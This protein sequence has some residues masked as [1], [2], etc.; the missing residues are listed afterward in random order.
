F[1]DDRYIQGDTIKAN[2]AVDYYFGSPVPKALVKWRL[3]KR[4]R[5]SNF[6]SVTPMWHRWYCDV[7]R[8][9]WSYQGKQVATGEGRTDVDGKFAVS[10]PIPREEHDVEY[11]LVADVTD[12]SRRQQTGSG[13]VPAHQAS[14][15]L[16]IAVERNVVEAGKPFD[17]TVHA[18]DHGSGRPAAD[19]PIEVVVLRRYWQRKKYLENEVGVHRATTGPDGKAKI[20]LDVADSGSYRL[21]AKGVDDRDRVTQT[22]RWLWIVS[23]RWSGATMQWD[24]VDIVPD[25]DAYKLGDIATF[26][27]S[28]KVKDASILFTL[29]GEKLHS[30]RVVTLAGHTA[31]IQVRLRDEALVPNFYASVATLHGGSFYQRSK[32]I[33][34]DP[35][36]RFFSVEIKP[37]KSQYR[38]REKASFQLIAKDSQGRPVSAELALGIVDES[39]YALQEEFAADIRQFFVRRRWN[40]VRTNT[41]LRFWDSGRIRAEKEGGLL[42]FDS[43]DDAPAEESRLGAAAPKAARAR[44]GRAGKMAETEIRSNFAD[45][46]FWTPVVRTDENGMATITVDQLPDNLTTWRVTARGIST[47][48]LVGQEKNSVLVRKEL[49]V[50]LATPR[51]YT[52]G[53]KTTVS[54]IVRNDLPVAKDVRVEITATGIDLDGARE[55]TVHVAPRAEVRIDWPAVSS[56]QGKAVITVKALTDIESDALK[57]SIPVLPHGSLQWTSDA[58]LLTKTVRRELTVPEDTIRGA[59]ELLVTVSP[60]HAATVLDALEYL[61]S[62]PYGCVEQTMSRFLPTTITAQVLRRLKI[63]KPDLEAELPHMIRAGLQRLYGF[64]HQD[65]GW[66]WWKNDASNPFTTAYVVFG[67]A[68][69]R[70]ADVAV[71]AGV[72]QRGIQASRRMIAKAKSPEQRTYLLYALSAAGISLPDVRNALADDLDKLAPSLEAMLAIVLDKDG[73]KRE[74]ARVLQHLAGRAERTGG[75]AHFAGAKDYHWTGHRVDATALA[76]QAFLRVDPK[77]ELVDHVVAWLALNRQ[78]RYWVS[79]RQTALVVLAMSE[80]LAQSGDLMDPDMTILIRLNGE[81][82]LEKRVTKDNWYD[83]DG[84]VKVEGDRLKPGKNVLVLEKQGS[85]KPVYATYFRRFREAE[86]FTASKGGVTIQREYHLVRSKGIGKGTEFSPL[87][88][89]AEVKSGDEIQVTLT[90]R[91]DQPRR[92]LIVEDPLPAGCE[93]VREPTPRWYGRAWSYW[94]A[95]KEF[96]DEKVDIAVTYIGA[97]EQKVTY[98]MRAET[99]GRFRVLPSLVWNMY[100]PEEGANSN[101]RAL[102]IVDR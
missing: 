92:Y 19:R 78:G 4:P 35:M 90:V 101:G 58:G 15:G 2:V 93:P 29:E 22:T 46:M 5:W 36:H 77:H 34:V 83:F 89:G 85:G 68:Q 13:G 81:L 100:Q 23:E 43:S 87:A 69:A 66:G 71:D 62:Y 54:A 18:R 59:A 38:P 73:Q 1:G 27:I 67:L 97:G 10:Y 94:Y 39:I 32:S 102:T 51:F 30:Q 40:Q 28:S 37:D 11:T 70:A 41:S 60:S 21:V 72:F 56:Q 3:Y 49:Q 76:L 12:L 42:S 9:P 53:D 98:R 17:I 24:N 80:Y 16:G 7:S 88:S 64:Q 26:L 79:T 61:A 45:T 91:S 44:G 20:T 55:R 25:K 8:G 82:L 6:W 63:R 75:T 14:F 86:T 48:G 50:R 52:Q 47:T 84:N 33:G 74:A 96:R 65:G 31:T 95:H 99:P 57:R